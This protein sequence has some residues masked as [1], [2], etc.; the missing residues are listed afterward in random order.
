MS[1]VE[2]LEELLQVAEAA[3][4]A[5]GRLVAEGAREAT[6]REA[7]AQEKGSGDYVTEVDRASER[8][9]SGVLRD[10]TPG[11]SFLGEEGGGERARRSWVVDPLDGTTN[12]LHGFP[13][14]GVSVALVEDGRPV[15]GVV[16]APFL[17]RTYAG[18]RG[19][20]ALV[21]GEDGSRT[22]LAVSDR[23]V[24]RAVVGTGFPFRRKELLSRYLGVMSR[25]L[26]RFEDLRRPGAA[27]LDLAWVAE[28]VFDGFFE[29]SLSAWDVAAGG[30]LIEEAGGVVTDWNG[31]EG[32]LG[33]DILAGS[34]AVHA[35]LVSLASANAGQLR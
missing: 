15:I 12:F 7:A 20:G 2:D 1:S 27:A 24:G 35:E 5:G 19:L 9:I 28:G 21:V 3:A 16:H 10:A 6:A 32:W 17:G 18:A 29:L 31:G 4:R 23:P 14:V 13:A 33:G 22:P 11:I 34:R 25:A 26:E 30:L 8:E